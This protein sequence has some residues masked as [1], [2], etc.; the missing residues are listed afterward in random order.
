MTSVTKP[1]AAC[2]LAVAVYATLLFL[3]AAPREWGLQSDTAFCWGWGNEI[4]LFGRAYYAIDAQGGERP[5]PLTV[6]VPKPLV[7][8][9]ALLVR[10]FTPSTLAFRALCV[11][12]FAAMLLGAC[13]IW[14][15]TRLPCGVVLV[16][17]AALCAPHVEWALSAQASILYAALVVAAAACFVR[18]S[19]H[20]ARYAYA[21]GILLLLAGLARP[22]AWLFPIAVVPLLLMRGDVP[23]RDAVLAPCL[24]FAAPLIWA[25]LDCAFSGDPGWSARVVRLS[26]GPSLTGLGPPGSVASCLASHGRWIRGAVGHPIL[27]LAAIGALP[28]ILRGSATRLL[29]LLAAIEFGA[30][31]A[32]AAADVAGF[33]P[34]FVP[35]V[36]LVILLAAGSVPALV[37]EAIGRKRAWAGWVAAIAFCAAIVWLMGN[38]VRRGRGAAR[39]LS[40]RA[41]PLVDAAKSLSAQLTAEDLLVIP[42]RYIPEVAAELDLYPMSR[43]FRGIGGTGRDDFRSILVEGRPG[44]V[45]YAKNTIP[46]SS[47]RPLLL[48]ARPSVG[49]A[50]RIRSARGGIDIYRLLGPGRSSRTA[51]TPPGQR[52]NAPPAR[53][54]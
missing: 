9:A 12:A 27:V 19:D 15:P 35:L 23:K 49:R 41:G 16:V 40:G 44:W 47:A 8:A 48:A 17:P 39:L 14:K 53:N 54:P 1:L 18:R 11:A 24:G 36:L 37:C 7:I 26:W 31:F 22:A 34:R 43:R 29:L 50:V 2:A 38:G 20:A 13:T 10:I 46:A 28:L 42:T 3:F 51:T 25:A 21:G 5:Q 30:L 45:L 52:V 32:G 4:R 6:S 33:A